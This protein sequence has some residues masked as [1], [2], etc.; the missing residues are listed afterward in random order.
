VFWHFNVGMGQ[1]SNFFVIMWDGALAQFG[2][3]IWEGVKAY[4]KL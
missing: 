4:V 1:W 2:D 3:V